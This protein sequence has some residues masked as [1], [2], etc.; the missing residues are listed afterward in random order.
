M[1]EID[2]D[3]GRFATFARHEAL[4][5]QLVLDGVDGGDAE[6][7]AYATVRGR[8]AALAENPAP[9]RLP[10][11]RIDGEEVR[12]VAKLADQPHLMRNL[13]GVRLR[14][15]AIEHPLDRFGRQL[16]QGFLR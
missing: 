5:Q 9:A 7:E 11:D 16:L 13:V 1:L 8:A 15:L 3:V 2:V 12:R 10:H 6:H 4:E 14:H